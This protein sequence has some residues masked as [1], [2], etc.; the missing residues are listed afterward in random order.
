MEG[1]DYLLDDVS[2][3]GVN[4]IV[5]ALRVIDKVL[6]VVVYGDDVLAIEVNNEEFTEGEYEDQVLA[7]ELTVGVK[8]RAERVDEG[9]RGIPFLELNCICLV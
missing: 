3:V 7:M 1:K 9:A 4:N 8:M 2:A 5:H 6:I